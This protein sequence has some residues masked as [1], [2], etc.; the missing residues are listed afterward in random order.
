LLVVG[1][2]GSWLYRDTQIIVQQ[3]HI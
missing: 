2:L 3:P 1:L